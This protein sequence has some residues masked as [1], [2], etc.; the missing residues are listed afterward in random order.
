MHK[1]MHLSDKVASNNISVINFV[2]IMYVARYLFVFEF[3][4]NKMN[5]INV[6]MCMH[7]HVLCEI[8]TLTSNRW[9]V[10]STTV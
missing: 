6:Y 7:V 2:M 1:A 8:M 9:F 3:V 10:S 4:I 5:K